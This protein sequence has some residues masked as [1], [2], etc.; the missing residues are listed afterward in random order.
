M[1]NILICDDDVDF[2]KELATQIHTAMQSMQQ[3]AQ[4]HQ[5]TSAQ[6]INLETL[7]TCD[8]AFLDIDFDGQDY[9][10]IDIARM[11]RKI[12]DQIVIIFVTNFPEYAPDGYEVRAFRYLLKDK[13]RTKLK[14][15]LTEALKQITNAKR[16]YQI[17]TPGDAN[18]L[19]LDDVV[20][21]ESRNHEV[22]VFLKQSAGTDL[23]IKT[24]KCT[25]TQLEAELEPHGFLRIHRSYLVNMQ[26][27]DLY[28]CTKAVLTTGTTLSV[29]QQTYS[30]QKKKY[31]IWKGT[32]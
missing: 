26:Y 27:I 4:I 29:S 19:F 32:I 24:F 18:T 15:Y 16:A 20:Y 25:I 23:K 13:V 10:G 7:Q 3:Y 5:F 28:Q 6:E 22:T 8:I 31:L 14:P 17:L 1:T 9:T 2:A 11:L 21:I 30:E 12:S